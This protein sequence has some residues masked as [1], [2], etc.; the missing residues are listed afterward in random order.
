MWRL[1]VWLRGDLFD[2][3]K[4]IS[5]GLRRICLDLTATQTAGLLKLNRKTVNTLYQCFRLLIR[6]QRMN[7]RR[8]FRGV[9]EVNE[10][11]FG[12][13]RVRGRA[14]PRLRGRGTLNQPVFGIFE[15]QGEVYTEIINDCSAYTLRAI[16]RGRIDPQIVVCSDGWPATRDE[17]SGRRSHGEYPFA[18]KHSLRHEGWHRRQAEQVAFDRHRNCALTTRCSGATS[19]LDPDRQV[20]AARSP[21]PNCAEANIFSSLKYLRRSRNEIRAESGIFNKN[22]VAR[23]RTTE[24][25]R[26][27]R[28]PK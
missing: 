10:C 18:G 8:A 12:P 22:A 25:A 9:V 4:F 5:T 24:H 2:L 28:S 27:V 14:L 26:R 19:S 23:G 6:L 1:F 17:G 16:M 7:E 21:S 11:Y 15:R 3:E 20:M 13:S